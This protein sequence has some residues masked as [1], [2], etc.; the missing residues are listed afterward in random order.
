[1]ID[2]LFKLFIDFY[3]A[4]FD[5]EKNGMLRSMNYFVLCSIVAKIQFW[6]LNNNGVKISS[7]SS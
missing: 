4:V 5:L 6:I 3:R 7:D 2:V 1:M